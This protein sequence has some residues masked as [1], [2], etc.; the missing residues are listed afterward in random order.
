MKKLLLILLLS[1]GSFLS[2]APWFGPG[3]PPPPPPG[4]PPR[5]SLQQNAI[6]KRHISQDKLTYYRIEQSMNLSSE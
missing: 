4:P 5:F 2:C 3:G 1:C 6:Q